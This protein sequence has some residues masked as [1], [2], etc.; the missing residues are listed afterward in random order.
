MFIFHLPKIAPVCSGSLGTDAIICNWSGFRNSESNIVVHRTFGF[1][2]TSF[3]D[4]AEL[5]NSAE[6][7]FNIFNQ[8]KIRPSRIGK[9][10]NTKYFIRI[11]YPDFHIIALYK[12]KLIK[13][14]KEAQWMGYEI[15]K[16]FESK[17]VKYQSFASSDMNF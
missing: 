15:L 1:G 14:W 2:Q 7:Y 5:F 3:R 6:A 13:V 8:T 4:S 16:D 17:W 10:I 11:K 9:K 12:P